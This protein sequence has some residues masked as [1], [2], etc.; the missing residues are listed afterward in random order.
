MSLNFLTRSTVRRPCPLRRGLAI[1][2]YIAPVPCVRVCRGLR[3]VSGSRVGG[4]RTEGGGQTG[5]KGEGF[6]G[7]ATGGRTPGVAAQAAA[8]SK[9]PAPLEPAKRIPDATEET[10]DARRSRD[11]LL[12]GARFRSPDSAR[13]ALRHAATLSRPCDRPD[14]PAKV[15]PAEFSRTGSL[16]FGLRRRRVPRVRSRPATSFS[17]VF[18]P[19]DGPPEGGSRCV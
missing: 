9:A 11:T 8:P 15:R 10:T 19:S 14:T 5:A 17:A 1:G 3:A 4:R 18:G 16:P 12:L 7:R 2:R 13:T 6:G